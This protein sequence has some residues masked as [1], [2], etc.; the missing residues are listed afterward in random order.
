MF[1]RCEGEQLQK[2]D[3]VNANEQATKRPL[4]NEAVTR[5]EG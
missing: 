2:I 4:R 1:R 3:L 5:R